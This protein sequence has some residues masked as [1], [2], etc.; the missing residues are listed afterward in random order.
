MMKDFSV[1]A[2]NFLSF[3][4]AFDSLIKMCLAVTL[5]GFIILEAYLPSWIHWFTYF[6]K[7]WKFSAILLFFYKDFFMWT[8]CKV[9]LICYNIV[10]VLW[11]FLV[12]FFGCEACGILAPWP[13]VEPSLSAL[14]GGV[15]TTRPTG[16]VPFVFKIFIFYFFALSFLRFP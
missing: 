6:T 5:F 14:E 13:G 3:A 2:L 1:D 4:L 12:L 11:G 15:L 16:K 10:S 8:I 9:Y 7:F